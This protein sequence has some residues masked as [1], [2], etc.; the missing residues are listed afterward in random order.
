MEIEMKNE[1]L[2]MV[3][4]VVEPQQEQITAVYK[5]KLKTDY[6]LRGRVDPLLSTNMIAK[7][8]SQLPKEHA[9]LILKNIDATTLMS[10]LLVDNPSCNFVN[11]FYEFLI[12]MKKQPHVPDNKHHQMI[13]INAMEVWNRL[14]VSE[15]YVKIAVNEGIFWEFI[16][17]DAP[18][19]QCLLIAIETGDIE[20]LF[21]FIIAFDCLENGL[22]LY[23]IEYIIKYAYNFRQFGII[24]AILEVTKQN[25]VQD[26]T[27]LGCMM[28]NL[29]DYFMSHNEFNSNFDIKHGS[30]N[31]ISLI[32]LLNNTLGNNMLFTLPE[33]NWNKYLFHLIEFDVHDELKKVMD[34]MKKKTGIR[35]DLLTYAIVN[36]KYAAQNILSSAKLDWVDT[37]N[38][39]ENFRYSNL[40][41]EELRLVMFN[42]V[43]N[44]GAIQ[45]KAR[46]EH[47]D[48]CAELDH[49]SFHTDVR[50]LYYV[51][52]QHQYHYGGTIVKRYHPSV[53]ISSLH[54]KQIVIQQW[55]SANGKMDDLIFE[56]EAA[57]EPIQQGFRQIQLN[58][59]IRVSL[60][61][62]C[63]NAYVPENTLELTGEQLNL[64]QFMF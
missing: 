56:M 61:C 40:S 46:K 33:I 55:L 44:M 51:R 3:Q 19:T 43:E 10:C 52:N 36:G 12:E 45:A 64:T 53:F 31:C 28:R 22:T 34:N 63:V 4:P 49:K 26:L 9:F 35:I 37:R 20:L 27:K 6:C 38:E 18:F 60:M 29:V 15:H 30:V 39:L 50:Q 16:S 54:A 59:Q 25:I 14:M 11:M 7:E 47:S 32:N 21:K 57:L 5:R 2:E 8:L 42:M 24:E 17:A 13:G 62:Q 41:Y 48:G 58:Y 23:I 1:T